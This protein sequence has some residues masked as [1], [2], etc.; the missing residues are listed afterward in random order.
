MRCC[1]VWRGHAACAAELTRRWVTQSTPCT[2]CDL[3]TAASTRRRQTCRRGGS[4]SAGTIS[5]GVLWSASGCRSARRS[6]YRTTSSSRS[7]RPGRSRWRS[8]RA[9]TL[10]GHGRRCSTTTAPAGHSA[11]FT[12]YNTLYSDDVRLKRCSQHLDW[13]K[14]KC[15]LRTRVWTVRV[16][17]ACLKLQF[18]LVLF[19]FCDHTVVA[20]SN[21]LSKLS[22]KFAQFRKGNI[23]FLTKTNFN[24]IAIY[25]G[26][27]H[28][29]SFLVTGNLKDV[30]FFRRRST[31]RFQPL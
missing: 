7:S 19:M 13:T 23:Y 2:T 29:R 11:V 6:S 27:R 15:C 31:L 16:E 8:T 22:P 12:L 18:S 4:Q 28:F 26:V 9:S 3:L 14:L 24:I 10:G 21:A 1:R 5:V 30:G 17:C 20:P 25:G